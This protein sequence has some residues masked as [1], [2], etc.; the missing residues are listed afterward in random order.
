MPDGGPAAPA[1]PRVGPASTGPGS[2][3]GLLEAFFVTLSAR[4]YAGV[5]EL[6]TDDVEFDLAYGPDVLPMPTRGRDAV[7]ELLGAVIGAI[8][9]PLRIEV[10]DTYPGREPGLVIAE[11]RSDGVAVA[12]GKPYR[13]RYI[14]VFR[15]RDGRLG[16]WKE[17]HNPDEVAE[18]MRDD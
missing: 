17:F 12:T 9:D 1:A 2:E 14:G 6:M 18:A 7:V 3:H 5:G 16:F 11:Y 13:N 15:F 4:D 10:T 8:F